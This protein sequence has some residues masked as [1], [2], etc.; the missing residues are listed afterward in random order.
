M[1]KDFMIGLRGFMLEI[2]DL[3]CVSG[4]VSDVC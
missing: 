3:I 2:K 4:L 1:R